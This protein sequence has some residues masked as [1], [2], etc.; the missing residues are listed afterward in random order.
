MGTLGNQ[1][2]FGAYGFTRT[3]AESFNGNGSATS[4]TLG[5]HVKNAIDIEVLVDNVQ[6][7]PFDGS[8]SV[9]G[10]TLTFSGAP[11]SGTNN[12]YVMYRQVGTVIDTQALVPDDN[13][14]TYAKLGNDIPLG[15][16]NL[17]INGDFKVSQR[18]TYSSAT[19]ITN[20]QYYIDRFACYGQSNGA[21]LTHTNNSLKL[22]AFTTATNRM[23]AMTKLEPVDIQKNTTYTLSFYVT[24]NSSNFRVHMNDLSSPVLT[25]T[26]PSVVVPNGVRTKVSVPVTVGSTVTTVFEIAIGLFASGRTNVAITSGDYFV[27]EEVQ[28]EVGNKATPFE[29]KNVGQELLACQRYYQQVDRGSGIAPFTTAAYISLPY[30]TTMRAIPTFGT[31][32]ALAIND[33]RVNAIQSTAHVTAYNPNISGSFIQLNN[34]SGLVQNS[35]CLMRGHAGTFV[36]LDAEL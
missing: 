21:K 12:V 25:Y 33:A 17:V 14:V 4:F 24:T 1:P 18:G 11:A 9:S 29:H 36:T 8:Y 30:I 26:S 28:L 19:T 3:Q 22:E 6:Q 5:H 10:T 27:L 15:N 16:R 13:S 2:N 20:W 7:S 31:T 35:A 23:F 34:F 32:G